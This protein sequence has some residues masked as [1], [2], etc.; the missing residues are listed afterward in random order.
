M[1]SGGDGDGIHYSKV[2]VVTATAGYAWVLTAEAET[3][4]EDDFAWTLLAVAVSVVG[5]SKQLISTTFI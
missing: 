5:A 1:D 4:V 2:G 3:R